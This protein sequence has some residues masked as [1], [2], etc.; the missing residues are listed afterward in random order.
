[1]TEPLTPSRFPTA[2]LI[3]AFFWILNNLIGIWVLD[4]APITNDA[5]EYFDSAKA[6][7]QGAADAKP[8]Y[9]PPGGPFVLAACFSLLGSA[10]ESSI[11][12]LMAALSA[13]TTGFVFLLGREV[14]QSPRVGIF[15][16]MLY[17]MSPTTIFMS[18]QSEG[19][20]FC[21]FWIALDGP[22][23]Q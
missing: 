20:T 4:N 8:H 7:W 19:H 15:A 5:R 13:A 1:M 2:L 10:D 22:D 14:F 12:L 16:A 18:R 9:W 6:F 21:A 23:A 3:F 17:S 11:Q